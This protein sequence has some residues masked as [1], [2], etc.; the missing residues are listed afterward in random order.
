MANR[1]ANKYEVYAVA[2]T[3]GP[4]LDLFY[5]VGWTSSTYDSSVADSHT[6]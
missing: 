4:F 3:D 5:R 6:G 2:F 1:G